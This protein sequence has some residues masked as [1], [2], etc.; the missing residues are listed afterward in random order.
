[1]TPMGVMI[2]LFGVDMELLGFD[3]SISY[4]RYYSFYIENVGSW[5]AGHISSLPYP[6]QS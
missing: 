6:E 5:T 2:N 3:C 1:M 4:D